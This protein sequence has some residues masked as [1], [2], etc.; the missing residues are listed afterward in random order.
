MTIAV[1][2]QPTFLPWIGY[3]A[4]IALADVFVFYDDVQFVRQSFHRRN[5]IRTPQGWKYLSVPVEAGLG[6]TIAQVRIKY[7]QP[8]REE[9]RK[10]LEY[11]YRK[12]LHFSDHQEVLT[13]LYKFPWKFLGA[14]TSAQIKTI[15]EEA[16]L[17]SDFVNSRE[18]GP[19]GTK[20]DR[21]I[22]TV[23]MV[24]ATTYVT[25]PAASAYLEPEKFREAGID[26]QWFLFQHPTYEQRFD[27]FY[28]YMTFLDLLFNT[29]ASEARRLI[30]EASRNSLS[31]SLPE[32]LE[33]SP[34]LLRESG[35]DGGP[36]NA[37]GE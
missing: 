4:Q 2:L 17:R 15:A 34:T 11:C 13:S 8:W 29:G 10:T 14:M 27:G 9:H 24:G 31:K 30:V 23:K 7:D 6:D 18:L 37:E 5:R 36:S 12:A 21:L 35:K 26:L 16:G 20:T 1:I 19:E 33:A 3:F 25:G 32:G 22:N 28:P